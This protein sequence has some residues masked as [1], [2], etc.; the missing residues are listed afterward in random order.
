LKIHDADAESMAVLIEQMPEE[1]LFEV[2][3]DEEYGTYYRNFTE[4]SSIRITI[5]GK[6]AS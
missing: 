6:S 3:V 4:L 5:W 2:F 1:K